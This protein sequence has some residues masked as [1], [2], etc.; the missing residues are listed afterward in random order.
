MEGTIGANISSLGCP[1]GHG[2]QY[3]KF[4]AL[5]CQGNVTFTITCNQYWG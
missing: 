3:K 4:N 2:L 1:H 5:R